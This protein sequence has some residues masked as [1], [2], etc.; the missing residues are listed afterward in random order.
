MSDYVVCRDCAH[1]RPLGPDGSHIQC[2]RT[3][4]WKIY[5]PTHGCGSGERRTYGYQIGDEQKG[6]D[7]GA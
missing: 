2:R 6:V 4:E 5:V 7:R 3:G 1:A